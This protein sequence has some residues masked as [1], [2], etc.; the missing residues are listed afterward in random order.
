[1][2]ITSQEKSLNINLTLEDK[3]VKI[4]LTLPIS[5]KQRLA[6]ES[7][8][9]KYCYEPIPWVAES[10]KQENMVNIKIDYPEAV[11][12]DNLDADED[13]NHLHLH[14]VNN[15]KTC[16]K[17]LRPLTFKL[18]TNDPFIQELIIALISELKAS[19]WHSH[20]P[21][22][23]KE[24]ILSFAMHRHTAIWKQSF[25]HL[26]HSLS[27]DNMK[28]VVDY[29][30]NHLDQ[31]LSLVKMA[32]VAQMSLF[33]FARQFKRSIGTTPHQYLNQC[34]IE[35]A[36]QLLAEKRLSILEIAQ[37]VGLQSPSHFTTLFRRS[38]GLT[39]SA[40]RE[41]L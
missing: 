6:W 34:R 39:P 13:I 3:A 29:I 1:M 4:S 22:E 12:V 17:M 5:Y 33:H 30:N 28:Q 31:E 9:T 40:Y 19:G 26:A 38:V 20:F 25:K 8:E 35:K 14:L 18:S 32:S 2:K 24:T 27:Q 23:S 21:L 41:K 16:Q 36:K 10:S 37:Q 15:H 11:K 7:I